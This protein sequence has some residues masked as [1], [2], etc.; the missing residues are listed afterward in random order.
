MVYAM[1]P[2][3]RIGFGALGFC[4]QSSESFG[5]FFPYA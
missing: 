5:L 3:G 2:T 4:S 1:Y